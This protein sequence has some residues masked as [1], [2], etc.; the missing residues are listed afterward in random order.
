MVGLFLYVF[1]I[2]TRNFP[3]IQVKMLRFFNAYLFFFL[4]LH[5]CVRIRVILSVRSPSNNNI[6]IKIQRLFLKPE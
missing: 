1:Y 4:I 2:L 5:K 3:F 6:Y